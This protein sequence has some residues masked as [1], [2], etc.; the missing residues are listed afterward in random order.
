MEFKI[1]RIFIFFAI[2]LQKNIYIL[3]GIFANFYHKN[4]EFSGFAETDTK[5]H[6]GRQSSSKFWP[7][8]NPDRD[9][10]RSTTTN[11]L[12]NWLK[13]KLE[14]FKKNHKIAKKMS[15]K[16]LEKN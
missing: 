16:Y 9:F 3:R 15:K 1:L 11:L 10:C 13:N 14:I 6:L 12:G 8:I 5:C 2:F 7:I 4:D